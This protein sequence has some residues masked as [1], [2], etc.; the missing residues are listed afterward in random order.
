MKAKEFA[1]GRV[2]AHIKVRIFHIESR[3]SDSRREGG[4]DQEKSD[5]AEAEHSDKM[6]SEPV[7]PKWSR[8]HALFLV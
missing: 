8:G 2:D 4:N 7:G 5:H 1:M 6:G 3:K